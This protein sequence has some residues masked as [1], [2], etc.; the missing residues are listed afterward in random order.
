M[1]SQNPIRS[2][3]ISTVLILEKHVGREKVDD[4]NISDNSESRCEF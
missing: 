2:L 3:L 4:G 1:F